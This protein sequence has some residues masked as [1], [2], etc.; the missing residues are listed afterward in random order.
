MAK[1]LMPKAELER[2]SSDVRLTDEQ[3]LKIG[4]FA[5]LKR[6]PSLDKF[7][8][9]MVLRRY[10]KGEVI[11]RQGEAGWTA[12]YTL[13]SEDLL[14]IE[15]REKESLPEVSKSL[16][17][18]EFKAVLQRVQE[19]QSTPLRSEELRTLATVNLAVA[20]A[21]SAAP[22]ALP[23]TK[24]GADRAAWRT[25]LH[26]PGVCESTWRIAGTD[27]G[28]LVNK[29][30]KAP[31]RKKK[32]G[33]PTPMRVGPDENGVLIQGEDGTIFV[34]RG[35]LLASDA[36]ILSE[37]LKEDPRLYD[38]RPTNQMQ[39]FVD[40]VHSRKAPI[41]DVVVGG[42]VCTGPL[43]SG[44]AFFTRTASPAANITKPR[45]RL[46]VRCPS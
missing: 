36:K 32:D 28:E 39:N 42:G 31:E 13:T 6:K 18:G 23:G 3:F 7:P 5:Q 43:A 37:P 10:R 46:A 17:P 8:G 14:A 33:K 2:R 9:A 12:F 27:A 15:G 24:T 26:W 41:C 30:G 21:S 34:G 29:D 25:I 22:S 19:L 11:F 35:A 16:S 45:A 44:H 4:L 38:G 40:C 1:Q 20:G